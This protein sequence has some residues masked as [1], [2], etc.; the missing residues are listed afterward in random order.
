MDYFPFR[1][2][3]SQIELSSE[4][5]FCEIFVTNNEIRKDVRFIKS[6]GTNLHLESELQSLIDSVST[7]VFVTLEN[8]R[9]FHFVW[10]SGEQL[11]FPTGS[12]GAFFNDLEPFWLPFYPFVKRSDSGY[13]ID[14]RYFKPGGYIR[15]ESVFIGGVNQ[16]GHFTHDVL[17]RHTA[18]SSLRVNGKIPSLI[19]EP[20]AYQVPFIKA[21]STDN[22][23]L[24]PRVESTFYTA[25]RLHYAMNLTPWSKVE[26]LR[27]IFSP[28][29]STKR[30]RNRVYI[31][32]DKISRPSRVYNLV[33][34]DNAL[35][36]LGF[37]ILDPTSTDIHCLQTSIAQASIVVTDP[38]TPHLNFNLFSSDDATLVALLPGTVVH[39]PER[40]F[41]MGG[42]T[43]LAPRAAQTCVFPGEPVDLRLD[44][45]SN[46]RFDITS[47]QSV[48]T[49]IVDSYSS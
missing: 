33:E 40:S 43:L 2:L 18:Y 17:S 13:Y 46:C 19:L 49:S 11:M 29:K 28:R 4:P 7:D 44:H 30:S 37:E 23:L 15:E 36:S 21:M 8:A 48:I 20:L 10:P 25:K 27:S 41:L 32:R 34:I 12:T 5:D 6:R 9:I 3:Q 31:T 47:L 42:A 14:L 35:S 1:P 16:F 45:T 39:C 26:F 38:I 24:L 22:L